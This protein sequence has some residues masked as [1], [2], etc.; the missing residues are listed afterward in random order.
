MKDLTGKVFGYLTALEPCKG[1]NPKESYWR[2]RC[3]CGKETVV[4][5]SNLKSGNSTSCGCKTAEKLRYDIVGKTY[6]EWTVL[7]RVEDPNDKHTK[8]L[9]RC[10]CGTE[11]VVY[12]DNLIGNKSASCGCKV[13]E[14]VR[15]MSPLQFIGR[16][17]E[18][19]TVLEIVE[20]DISISSSDYR[21][22]CQ[23]ECENYL[24]LT[25]RQITAK[26][27]KSCGLCRESNKNA[28]EHLEG[29][30]FGKLTL[31]KRIDVDQ[32]GGVAKWLCRCDCGNETIVRHW[33]IMT[34][35]T[36]SCGC[37]DDRVNGK[38]VSR[39]Q[40]RVHEM[41]G[42]VMNY[43]IGPFWVDIV[44][45]KDRIAIEYDSHYW[46]K[47][48]EEVDERK[49]K[50]L[51]DQGWKLLRVKSVWKVPELEHL[52]RAV[53]VLKETPISYVELVLD[54]WVQREKQYGDYTQPEPVMC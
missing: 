33:N 6:G 11:R 18:K 32:L 54:D 42:G 15:K 41:F 26:T 29:C 31:I 24:V 43:Q 4:Q 12:Q 17:Y 47:Q 16:K 5:T 48:N 50:E 39:Q 22:R 30:K 45:V 8:W 28:Y 2:C 21:Y 20:G 49:N 40:R 27:P 10:S 35:N 23:C 1:K 44:S 37:L 19:I 14:K 53:S 52:E 46:H 13:V 38:P 3:K 9:C 7:E 34:G 36:R 51:F 25:A